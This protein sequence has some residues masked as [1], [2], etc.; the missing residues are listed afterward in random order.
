MLAECFAPDKSWNSNVASRTSRLQQPAR[1]NTPRSNG[2][3][4]SEDVDEASTEDRAIIIHRKYGQ[5]I[6]DEHLEFCGQGSKNWLRSARSAIQEAGYV[7]CTSNSWTV[8]CLMYIFFAKNAGQAKQC[9]VASTL[10]EQAG[11]A[12]GPSSVCH[13]GFQLTLYVFSRKALICFGA[14]QLQ[15][16]VSQM[17]PVHT[18]RQS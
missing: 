10:I 8:T 16:L 15:H 9:G 6:C 1:P 11:R 2:A 4:Q 18:E 14:V 3:G 12:R 13:G 5:Y 7:C 17:F